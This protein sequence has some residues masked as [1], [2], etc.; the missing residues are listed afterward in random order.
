M[1]ES[2]AI[3]TRRLLNELEDVRKHYS[4]LQRCD[5]GL[6]FKYQF[7]SAQN[8]EVYGCVDNHLAYHFLIIAKRE[9]KFKIEEL[10]SKLKDL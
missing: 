1:T 6:S 8:D 5:R 9:L 3:H 7:I 10:E 2:K 4:N